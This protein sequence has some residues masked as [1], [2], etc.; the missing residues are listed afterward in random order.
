MNVLWNWLLEYCDIDCA[1][2]AQ[3]GAA[4]LTRAGLEVESLT[5]LGAGFRGVV[6]AEVVARAPHPNA[7]KLRIVSV[8]TAPGGAVTEVVCG[9]PNV[10]EPGGRVLWAQ[11][12]A[13]L[14]GGLTL[15]PKAVKGVVSPGMLCSE[16]ELGIGDDDSGIIIL[17]SDDPTP[18]GAPAQR[19]L[20]LDEWRME[21]KA[22]ANRGD[23]LS[24]V[25][26]A[27]ELVSLVGGRVVLPD[28]TVPAHLLKAGDIGV[29]VQVA[30]GCQRYLARR[31]EGVGV[32]PSPRRMAQRLRNV[33]V[34]PINHVVDVTNYVMFELGHP[35]HA[36][37]ADKLQHQTVVARPATAPAPF[38]TLDGQRREVVAGDLVIC[39]GEQVIAL[40]GVMGGQNSEV[41]AQTKN[42]LLEAAAFD[43]VAIRRTARRLSLHSEASH[44][45]ERH[46]DPNGV[47]FAAARAVALLAQQGATVVAAAADAYPQPRVLAPVTLRRARVSA[48]AGATIADAAITETLTRLGCT[49][50]ANEAAAGWAITPPSHRFDLTREID[51]IEE[52]LRL[53]GYDAIP[54]RLP[55]MRQAPGLP[56][57]DRAD[58]VR[59]ALVAAGLA[60]AITFG[61][62]SAARVAG[63]AL[64]A[65]DPRAQPLPLRNPMS[66][67]H[68]VM[69]TSLVPNLL[70]AVARNESFGERDIAMFEVGT[71]FLPRQRNVADGR[72]AG[73]ADEREMLVGVLV[74]RRHGQFGPGAAWDV[75]AAKGFAEHAIAA[76]AGRSAGRDGQAPPL[77]TERATIPY[78]HPGATGELRLGGVAVGCFGEVHPTVRA[79]FGVEQPVM[80]FEIQVDALPWRAPTQMTPIAKFPG[81]TRDI[82]MLV[83]IDVP[84]ARAYD[85]FGHGKHALLQSVQL[86]E[87][88]RD[89]KLPPGK[90]SLLYSLAYRASDR[91]LTDAEIDAAHSAVVAE[92]VVAM[93][94]QTR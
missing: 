62:T 32:G 63:L 60:E 36:F 69:R 94:A 59:D 19:A 58:Q 15:A 11:V 48:I 8:I 24:H 7:D 67:E 53:Q 22:P 74:G 49:V 75:F 33:G 79:A 84:A 5:D 66:L 56:T 45:F 85:V 86:R 89:A 52:V 81:T 90:K 21:I 14:P 10:P 38:V 47:S 77:V 27:R 51:L 82:S 35:L 4:L 55:A 70:A 50:V 25:G 80:L 73:L 93:G 87:D 46:V 2:T 72:D 92:L 18:L 64:P 54:D 68:A 1:L 43:A 40:A 61:F 91:T 28:V 17:P 12:G 57:P 13:V 31:L 20:G 9:A 83:E 88:F 42:I 29:R 78:L 26:L 37:D 65:S 41:D 16:V 3:E 44:R 23:I 6:V 71:V 76:V 34:R 39:D 30:D